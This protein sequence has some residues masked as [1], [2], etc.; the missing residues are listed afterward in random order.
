MNAPNRVL[1]HPLLTAASAVALAGVARWAYGFATDELVCTPLFHRQCG[2]ALSE[3]LDRL[4]WLRRVHPA[5]R[6]E[7]EELWI[8]GLDP[9]VNELC[10]S[11]RMIADNGEIGWFESRVR[12][13][14]RNDRGHPV[15]IAGSQRDISRDKAREEELTALATRD[16]VTGLYNRRYFRDVLLERMPPPLPVTHRDALVLIDLNNFNSIND[17]LGH[18]VGDQV[19]AEVGRRLSSLPQQPG[20]ALARAGGDEFALLLPDVGG[21]DGRVQDMVQRLTTLLSWPLEVAGMEVVLTPSIGVAIS[22]EHGRDADT[23]FQHADAALQSAKHKP[24]SNLVFFSEELSRAAQ[25]RLELSAALRTAQSRNELTLVYQPQFDPTGATLL[26]MEALLRWNHPEL[27]AVSP[28][29][30]VPVAEANGLMP[31]L[32]EWVLNEA[33]R[34]LAAWQGA[35]LAPR[36]VS[37][38]VSAEQF[39]QPGFPNVVETTLRSHD[40]PASL[41]TLEITE[42]LLMNDPQHVISAMARLR[43]L[44]VS[45]EIDDFGTGYSSLAYLNRFPVHGLKIDRSFIKQLERSPQDRRIVEATVDLAHDLGLRVTA[46]GIE[47]PSQAELI[48]GMGCEAVQGFLFARPLPSAAI[49]SLLHQQAARATA[50]PTLTIHTGA[51]Q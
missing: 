2:L 43:G 36:A 33:C 6:D 16:P 34:Q 12:V 13:V 20:G 32:G 21:D 5:D 50:A 17:S 35:G 23:L 26:G 11:Y 41:L 10:V 24:G 28:A 19:L 51:R 44:G 7:W 42:S 45:L 38:N 8:F 3:P 14:G 9:Q 22:P 27:G 40:V 18:Q 31:Q 37:V 46:E 1:D 39:H 15:A 49:E 25:R 30:F 4:T 47:T 29:E 48:A